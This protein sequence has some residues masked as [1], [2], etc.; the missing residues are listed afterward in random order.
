MI[1]RPPRSTLFPYTTLF[2]SVF[3]E[4]P[5]LVD[6]GEIITFQLK[7]FLFCLLEQNCRL[8]PFNLNIDREGLIG[9]TARVIREPDPSAFFERRK[10][11]LIFVGVGLPVCHEGIYLP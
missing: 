7:P 3:G 9:T 5:R 11:H 2:R 6:R 10:R 8:S 4:F 1:R